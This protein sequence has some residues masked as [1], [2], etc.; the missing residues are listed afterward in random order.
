[1]NLPSIE[2]FMG[3]IKPTFPTKVNVS[4]FYAV[5]YLSKINNQNL[6]LMF[7]NPKLSKP[8]STKTFIMFLENESSGSLEKQVC[9]Y[10]RSADALKE[11]IHCF[12]SAATI[13]PSAFKETDE[14]VWFHGIQ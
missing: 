10:L 11:Q 9:F 5:H 14:G 6:L 3:P 1:M 13:H 7:V 4:D 12:V 2:D 8:D